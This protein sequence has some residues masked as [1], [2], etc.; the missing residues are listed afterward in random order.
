MRAAFRDSDLIGRLS[1]DEFGVVAPGLPARKVEV[2]RE[3]FMSINEE[4]SK[5]AGLPFT[6]SISIGPVDFTEDNKDLKDLLKSA[7]KVLYEEKKLKH[8]KKS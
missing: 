5:E 3:R 7:D 2:I 4:F 1:G 8:T 6:L